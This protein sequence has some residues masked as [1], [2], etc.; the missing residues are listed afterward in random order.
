M[1]GSPLFRM[2]APMMSVLLVVSALPV[3]AGKTMPLQ[4]RGETPQ[5]NAPPPAKEF[6]MDVPQVGVPYNFSLCNGQPVSGKT[7]Q[8][9]PSNSTT[10]GGGRAAG[11]VFALAQ[12]EQLPAG[13]TLDGYAGVIRGTPKAPWTK[14]VTICVRQLKFEDCHAIQPGQTPQWQ[15]QAREGAAGGS[16]LGK[17]MV[18][19]GAAGG[20]GAAIGVVQKN[21][22]ATKADCS[23]APWGSKSELDSWCK[24]CVGSCSGASTDGNSCRRC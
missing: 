14:P 8:C 6:K 13:L 15:L 11:Y 23:V 12:G 3:P 24:K 21:K 1:R 17:A 16:S 4:Q 18:L 9:M 19:L 10:V 2:M 7:R 22:T 20:T 5:P